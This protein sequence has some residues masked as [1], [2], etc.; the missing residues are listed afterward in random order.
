MSSQPIA[1]RRYQFIDQAPASSDCRSQILAGLKKAPKEISPRFFYDD[2]GSALFEEITCQ[3]EYY[4]T[5]T[6]RELL[7]QHAG[8]IADNLPDGCT[9]V[10]PGAGSCEKVRL[11]LDALRPARYVPVDIAGGFLCDAAESL[12]QDFP[13]LPVTAIAADFT[14]VADISAQLPRQGRV[15]FY[16][17]S[18]LGNFTPNDALAFLSSV[19]ALLDDSGYLLIGVDRHKDSEVLDAAYNDRAGVTARFNLNALVHVNRL[20]DADFDQQDFEHV[21]F[22]NEQRRRIEMHLRCRR[23]HSVTCGGEPV[24]FEAGETILT[25]LSHKYTPEAFETLAGRAGLEVRQHWQDPK[26]WFSLFLCA[27]A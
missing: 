23:G 9:L 1:P 3:P 13:W 8:D 21:A 24:P 6:E 16:P 26:Q 4:P 20:A 7:Q 22:Y 27:P 19:R 12:C 25:E 18:T 2:T 5:R 11:L 17:G 10:E 14:E 15:V